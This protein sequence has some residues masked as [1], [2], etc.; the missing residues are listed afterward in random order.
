[1]HSPEYA[2]CRRKRRHLDYLSAIRHA[3]LVPENETVVVYPCEFCGGLHVGH[4]TPTRQLNQSPSVP[5][6][7]VSKGIARTKRR[8]ERVLKQ[9]HSAPTR[10]D[11][12]MR[13][14]AHQRLRDLRRYL[15]SLEANRL[16]N[17]PT[18]APTGASAWLAQLLPGLRKRA[19]LFYSRFTPV[20]HSPLIGKKC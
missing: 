16:Q 17:Q 10:R 3:A 1:M 20:K 5:G 15:V 11:P 19:R 7:L 6:D 8:I 2:R 4:Q 13:R 12:E 9:M 18:S 14:R